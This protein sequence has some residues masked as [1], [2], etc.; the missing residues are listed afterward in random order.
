MSGGSRSAGGSKR[1]RIAY[2]ND[3]G[4]KHESPNSDI[5]VTPLVDVCLVLL[6]IFMVVTPMLGRGR[7]VRLPTLTVAA[8]HKEGDQVFVSVDDE[9]AWIEQDQYVDKSSFLS[10]LEEDLKVANGKAAAT[11]YAGPVLF[12]KGDRETNYGHVR[13]VMEWINTLE[14]PP[15]EIALVV[16]LTDAAN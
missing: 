14:I 1:R 16:D 10:R 2:K 6:I 7:D 9:G 8:E 12:V 13:I 11:G 4:V 15:S 5:N 3:H